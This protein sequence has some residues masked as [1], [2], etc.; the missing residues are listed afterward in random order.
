MKILSITNRALLYFLSE[1]KMHQLANTAIQ[2]VLIFSGACL[3]ASAQN[4][5]ANKEISSPCSGKPDYSQCSAFEAGFDLGKTD[6]ADRKIAEYYRHEGKYSNS[7][8]DAF[9]KGYEMG[10]SGYYD[11]KKINNDKVLLILSPKAKLCEQ[12]IKAMLHQDDISLNFK[13]N[14]SG[15]TMTSSITGTV[16]TLKEGG[17]SFRCELTKNGVISKAELNI[18]EMPDATLPEDKLIMDNLKKVKEKR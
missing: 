13:N 10:W 1:I 15:E 4:L 11:L 17:R 6:K 2:L 14:N 16:S 18:I 7:N 9:V 5:S 12:K 3:N 8:E